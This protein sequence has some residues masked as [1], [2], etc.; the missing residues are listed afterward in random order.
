MQ[1]GARVVEVMSTLPDSLPDGLP[2]SHLRGCPRDTRSGPTIAGQR[3]TS[4]D[5]LAGMKTT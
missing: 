1:T 5:I 4:S 2:E 3:R